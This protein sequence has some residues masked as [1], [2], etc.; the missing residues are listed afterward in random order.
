MDIIGYENYLIYDDGRVYSKKR[1]IFLKPKDNGLGYKQLSLCN[2]GKRKFIY[3]HR[4]VSSHYIPNPENKLCVDH[5]DRNRSNNNVNNLRWVTH[6]ENSQNKGDFKKKYK[7]NT[8]GVINIR[9]IKACDRW[10]YEKTINKTIH[11]KFFKTFEEAVE[12]KKEYEFRR[13]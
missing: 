1:N 12:Y 5:I 6:R 2:N 13:C 10:K 4:L 11:N 7:N 8:S 9:F 3:I